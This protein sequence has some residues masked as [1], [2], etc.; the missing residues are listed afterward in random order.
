VIQDFIDYKICKNQNKKREK[1]REKERK[2]MPIEG[3]ADARI[4]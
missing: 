1:K 3:W 4:G 2:R